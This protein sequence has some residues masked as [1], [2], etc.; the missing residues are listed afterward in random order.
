MRLK[1]VCREVVKVGMGATGR[2]L[3]VKKLLFKKLI[4]VGLVKKN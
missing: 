1:A 3:K 4:F 2:L